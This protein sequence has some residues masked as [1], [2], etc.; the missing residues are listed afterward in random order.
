MTIP[1]HGQIRTA[2]TSSR[3]ASARYRFL[4]GCVLSVAMTP[5]F[6]TEAAPGP[7]SIEMPVLMPDAMTLPDRA[8]SLAGDISGMLASG[9]TAAAAADYTPP[10][11]EAKNLLQRALTLLGTPYRWGG[12][13]PDKGFDCSGLVSYVFQNALGIDLPRV[14]REQAN[15]GEPVA[16]KSDLAE[17]DLVFF[18]NRG[19]INH[20]GI[21]LGEG[22]F[23]HAPST[24]KDVMVSSLE[25]GYWSGKY[26]QARRLHGS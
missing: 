19:R 3:R 12:T 13:S 23:V 24:G 8:L 9:K 22:R 7:G 14:S 10:D 15:A 18:G 25:T 26:V 21:Y 17:G 20:V 5:A 16:D 11:R 4:L 1:I 2:C 6:A